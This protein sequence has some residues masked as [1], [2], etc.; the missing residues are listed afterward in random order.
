MVQE[1]QAFVY[2]ASLKVLVQTHGDH[3]A[4][5]VH[6]AIAVTRKDTIT[7]TTI[8]EVLYESIFYPC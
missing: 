3:R 8:R 5:R 6:L 4:R 2:P 7:P 1:S